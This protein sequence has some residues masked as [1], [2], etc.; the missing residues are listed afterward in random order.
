MRVDRHVSRRPN[1]TISSNSRKHVI[2]HIDDLEN[3]NRLRFDMNSGYP[4]G[5]EHGP[6]CHCCSCWTGPQALTSSSNAGNVMENVHLIY[7]A[8]EKFDQHTFHHQPSHISH[9]MP[10]SYPKIKVKLAYVTICHHMYHRY[11]YI[12]MYHPNSC[13][14]V[15]HVY[16]C[17]IFTSKMFPKILNDL[18]DNKVSC[19]VG[20]TSLRLG[21]DL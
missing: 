10:G 19:P 16:V 14:R 20:L 17:R 12:Y 2:E 1:H 4:Q 21:P 18:N 5:L 8:P 3:K 15:L 7:H 13:P 6:H 9:I 11:I